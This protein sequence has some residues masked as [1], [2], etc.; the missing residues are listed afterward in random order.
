MIIFARY[1]ILL[2]NKLFIC[3]Q[4]ALNIELLRIVCMLFIVIGHI[5][6]RGGVGFPFGLNL[7]P[8]HVDCFILISGYFLIT[9]KFKF[10]RILRTLIETIFYTFTITFILFCFGLADFY[11][12]AKSIFPIA[13]TKFNY[14]FVTKYLAVLLMSPFLSKLCLSLTQRGY[15]CLLLSLL[16]ISSTLFAF[17]FATMS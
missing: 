2:K 4:R 13:P 14:W 3:M 11:E 6:G 9:A 17:S 8:H 1:C 12:L 5:G 10:E 7:M 15:E 16:L